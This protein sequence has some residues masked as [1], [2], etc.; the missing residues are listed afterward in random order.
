MRLAIAILVLH[1]AAAVGA[2]AAETSAPRPI[3][4]LRLDP[5]VV[6]LATAAATQRLVVQV[7]YE[8]GVTED[9]TDRCRLR[10]A[11]LDV[12]TLERGV[13]RPLGD[14]RT[15]IE[16]RFAAATARA[17]V[18]VE[19]AA[20]RRPVRFGPDVLPVL[21]KSGCNSGPCH[22]SAKGQD[23]FLLSL[24][25]FDPSRDYARVTREQKSRRIDLAVPPESLLLRKATGA[26]PHTGGR[27][28]D[29]SHPSYATI[30]RWLED[31]AEADPE[32]VATA[33]SLELY[34]NEAVLGVEGATQ[35]FIAV[36]GYDDGSKR[37]VTE[38]CVFH[39]SDPNSAT[40]DDAGLVVAGRHGEAFITAR[41]ATFTVGSPVLVVP[42]DASP[43]AIR[44]AAATNDLDRAIL[45]K[46]ARLRVVPSSRCDDAT[47]VRRAYIDVIGRLP[48]PG[49]TT[50][51]LADSAPDKRARLVDDLLDRPAFV[52]L[53]VMKWS[54]I[55]QIRTDVLL[56]KSRKAMILY[57]DWLAERV[58]SG[59]PIDAMVRELL[60]ASGSTFES[61]PA[62][63]FQVETDTLKLAENTAQAFLGMRIQCAQCHNHP[64]DRWTMGDYYGFT[65]FFAQVAR[66][67]GPDPRETIV[68]D[69]GSGDVKHPVTGEVVPPRFLGDVAP[70]TGDRD[71]REV[72]AEWITSPDNPYF[73]RN[74]ANRVWEHF[75]GRGIV[76][77][78][79]DVRI[80]NPPS[81][82]LLLERLAERF[83]SSGYDL[84][85]LV[86]AICATE[87]YQRSTEP[88][89]TNASDERNFA[90]GTIRRLRAEVL[91]DAIGQVTGTEEKFTGLPRGTLAVEVTDGAITNPFLDTFG[92]ASRTSACACDVRMEPNLGQALH[93]LNGETTWKR[94]TDGGVIAS[95]AEDG[96]APV[97]I[98]DELY[99]R[100]LARRPT[101]VERGRLLARVE[102][103]PDATNAVLEDVFWALLNSKEFLF[104]H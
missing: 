23:G 76:D 2:A 61:P 38:L 57:S 1:L 62:N 46:L 87:A 19:R 51:F 44:P 33:T 82:A 39:S 21:T 7:E 56:G 86:R 47:F 8:N 77:P 13:V 9:V 18:R 34:P 78:V 100:C 68:F 27:R 90:R 29:E 88:T 71:R 96:A 101:D 20:A 15:S 10:V 25:G 28:F 70:R 55:L 63:Y 84:K 30:L 35:R 81:N 72:L 83:R 31:G 89:P 45:E 69:R 93:L 59:A 17:D 6:E 102:D 49:E 5:P 52:D 58:A 14:G 22:G 41:F 48:S 103:E 73:A 3:R 16:A 65:S 104:N 85:S 80:S 75:L 54:E 12:A 99:L 26:V 91:L 53:W 79:D 92:R 42:E 32:G 97:T 98:L 50:R 67:N 24:F 66:K 95:L 43:A 60:T 94:I 37:D 11:D 4:A 74:V 64:F 40:V 36:S